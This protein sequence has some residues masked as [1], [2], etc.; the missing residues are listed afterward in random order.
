M[1]KYFWGKKTNL[2]NTN[3]FVK[4]KGY[5]TGVDRLFIVQKV[6]SVCQD[7]GL[8]KKIKIELFYG[9]ITTSGDESS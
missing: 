9:C 7:P 5:K 6:K 1:P 2:Q 3:V 4:H 8:S